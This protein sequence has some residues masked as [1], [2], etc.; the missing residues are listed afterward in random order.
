M[1]SPKDGLPGCGIK[2]A[3]QLARAGHGRRLIEGMQ[4][5]IATG[6]STQ[7]FLTEWRQDLRVE[8]LTNG[9]G[10]LTSRHP[11]LA[12]IMPDTFP[13]LDVLK[14]Y[15]H[16]TAHKN[17]LTNSPPLTFSCSEPQAIKL[18]AIA[19]TTF[20]WG[21]AMKGIFKHYEE[22]F[23]PAMAIRQIIQGAADIDNGCA[24]AGSCCPIVGEIVLE[25]KAA[26]TCFLPE[27]RVLLIIPPKL[28]EEI[29][30]SLP[31]TALSE[32]AIAQIKYDCKKYRAWL[33]RAMIE[34][35]RPD[36]IA[37][38]KSSQNKS[39]SKC[40]CSLILT[41]VGLIYFSQSHQSGHSL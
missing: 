37:A 2:I 3:A 13:D 12:A 36:L 29:C 5:V 6:N 28:I 34:V 16:P 27:V 15:L 35:V 8:L 25:R 14:L 19:S 33:P 38:Y 4:D 20:Q 1:P 22:I 24:I 26:S 31:G 17:N 32:S 11:K 23:F 41:S 21:R 10:L 9:S 18:T 40:Y 30:A 39:S 7:S